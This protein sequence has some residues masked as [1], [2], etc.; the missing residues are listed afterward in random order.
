MNSWLAYAL[1]VLTPIGLA[2]LGLAVIAIVGVF[3]DTSRGYG[4][5]ACGKQWT[6]KTE[7]KSWKA[8]VAFER[9]HFSNHRQQRARHFIAVYR[10]YSRRLKLRILRMPYDPTAR[11]PWWAVIISTPIVGSWAYRIAV[12][13][14]ARVAQS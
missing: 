13:H 4:C 12:R 2:L 6:G 8:K 7:G 3:V 9:H 1:G 5:G 11:T 14:G 10:G